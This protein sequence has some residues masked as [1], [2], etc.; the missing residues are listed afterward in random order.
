MTDQPDG[1]DR[2]QPENDHQLSVRLAIEAGQVLVALR[3]ELAQRD[4]PAWQIM[5]TGDL[6]S[7]RFLVRALNELHPDDAVLSEEGLDDPRRFTTDRVWIIDPLD[8]TNEFGQ[9]ERSDWAVHVA[10]WAGGRLAAGAVSLPAVG[11]VFATDPAPVLPPATRE[12]PRLVTSRT[13][14]PNS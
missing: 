5:D 14:N 10:L 3:D 11:L 6:A 12:R 8:G 4:A 9:R 1:T 2:P 13:R 7:H